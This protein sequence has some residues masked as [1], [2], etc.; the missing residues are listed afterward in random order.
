M[1]YWNAALLDKGLL[2]IKTLRRLDIFKIDATPGVSNARHRV[3]ERLRTFCIDLNIYRVDTGKA[4]EQ[5]ALAFHDRLARQGSEI[6]QA[7]DGSAIRN[8]RHQVAFA[9]I[10]IGILGIAGDLAHRFGDTRAV[11]KRKI[12]SCCRG[13]GQFHREFSGNRFGVE[14]GRASCRERVEIWGVAGAWR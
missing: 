12:T 9:G 6:A 3:D 8:D 4:L 13:L 5:H 7:K 2:D 11:S 10:T 14:I 1:E